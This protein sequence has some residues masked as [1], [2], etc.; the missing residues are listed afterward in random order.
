MLRKKL[1]L[2][3][4]VALAL[5]VAWIATLKNNIDVWGDWWDELG[6][7][8][9][10]GQ[11]F[12]VN[13][14]YFSQETPFYAWRSPGFPFFL[15]LIYRLFG[16]SFL[17]A[18]IVLAVLNSFAA[19][20]VYLLGRILMGERVGTISGL[21]YAFYPAAIFW[22]GY[23][24]PDNL[25]VVILLLLLIFL[26][27]GERTHKHWFFLLAGFFLGFGVLSRSLFLVLLPIV[28]VWLFIR[29]RK[30]AISGTLLVFLG[31]AL[32]MV[33]WTIRN[34]RMCQSFVL[35]STEGGFVCYIANN[36]HSLSEP[37]GYWIPGVD[38]TEH[39]AGM[40]EVQIDHYWYREA[41]RFI[42]SQ[43]G[44][45]LRLTS[46]RFVRFWRF[47]LHTFSGPGEPY[48]NYQ[49]VLSFLILTPILLVS[50]YGLWF[51]F[52]KWRDFSL[53]YLVIIAWSLPVILFFKTVLRYREAIMPYLILFAAY[54]VC[55]I[56]PREKGI[57]DG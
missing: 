34:Y 30:I 20:L 3:F 31:C 19:V 35:T 13:N 2:I 56:I 12:W 51:S 5:R 25:F 26:L 10:N 4:L 44:E 9:A 32:V 37:S 42:R 57:E 21:I 43:P 53:L 55:N 16:H 22:T 7:R 54:A 6:W 47:Y 39:L 45:Y 36:S 38:V 24:A 11:G 46:D 1:F 29:N 14:P 49:A 8:L 28:F 23:L 33:P 15:S 52:R 18:K 40:S 17:A 50:F 48:K 41:F 27:F